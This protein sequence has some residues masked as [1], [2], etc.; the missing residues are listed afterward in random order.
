MRGIGIQLTADFDLD[1]LPIRGSDGK[2]KTGF[3]LAATLPQN[4][5]C[6]LVMYPGELKEVPHLGVGIE[7]MLLDND[8]LRWRRK[9][10]MNMELDGQKVDDVQLVKGKLI[11]DAKY[12][13]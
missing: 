2:I 9:I 12:N 10:R 3:R 6:I 5:A 8:W 7:D 4:Q 1:I 11:I 13:S